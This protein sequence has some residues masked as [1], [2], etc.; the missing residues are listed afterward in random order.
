MHP[1]ENHLKA[2][3]VSDNSIAVL[4]IL[5]DIAERSLEAV[6]RIRPSNSTTKPREEAV[7]I[8]EG[9]MIIVPS[10]MGQRP[11][12]HVEQPNQR[13]EPPDW[14]SKVAAPPIRTDPAGNSSDT[15]VKAVLKLRKTSSAARP[16]PSNVTPAETASPQ[17]ALQRPTP[18]VILDGHAPITTRMTKKNKVA[19]ATVQGLNLGDLSLGRDR[20]KKTTPA[21]PSASTSTSVKSVG[22]IGDR[23]LTGEGGRTGPGQQGDEK[24]ENTRDSRR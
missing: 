17:S 19:D 12:P 6:I 21:F 18:P 1:L 14:A 23:Q 9:P 10:A 8:A 11:P 22:V 3:A 7:S 4:S 20:F 13:V 16:S 15:K 2:L 5:T 24:R